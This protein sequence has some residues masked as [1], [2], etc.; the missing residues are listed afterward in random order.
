MLC[1]LFYNYNNCMWCFFFHEI[2][3][4]MH[5]YF[6][7]FLATLFLLTLSYSFITLFIW[8]YISFTQLNKRKIFLLRCLVWLYSTPNSLVIYTI[9]KKYLKVNSSIIKT[10][11]S[12]LTLSALGYFCLTMHQGHIVPLCVNPD[13]KMLLTWNLAQSYF[14]VLQKK[15]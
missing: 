4:H 7:M 10:F 2:W 15:W 11:N 12:E 13:R 14:V 6:I 9:F 8:L 1:V 3:R 5:L